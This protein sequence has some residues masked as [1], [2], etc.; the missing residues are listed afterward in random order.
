[1]RRKGQKW[2]KKKT[3]AKIKTKHFA[4]GIL[5][6]GT[7]TILQPCFFPISPQFMEI[8]FLWAQEKIARP[9]LL[10]L[11]FYSAIKHSNISFSLLFPHPLKLSQLLGSYFYVI[12]ISYDKTH[13]ICIL[14][15]SSRS[16]IIY[17]FLSKPLKTDC[18][19]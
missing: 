1:M 13:F 8:A 16:K 17:H 10:S 6:Q 2:K 3:K 19:T 9:L 18:L 12:G 7:P 11:T 14:V 5:I 4:M 15:N